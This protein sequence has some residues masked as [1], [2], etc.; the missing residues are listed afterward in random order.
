MAESYD[1]VVVGGGP[2][3]YVAAIR[4]AQLG[5]KTALIEKKELGGTCLNR[6]CIPTKALINSARLLDE[7]RNCGDKGIV[8]KE[9]SLN[10]EK[11]MERKDG[12]VWQLRSGVEYLLKAN[13]VDVIKGE[14]F[15]EDESTLCVRDDETI[16]QIKFADCIVATGSSPAGVA[17]EGA[18]EHTVTSDDLLSVKA[19][20]DRLVIIGGGVV[21]C[22]FAQIFHSFGSQ[23]TVVE[24]LPR[25]LNQADV[26][27]SSALEQEMSNKG[28]QVKTRCAVKKIRGTDSGKEVVLSCGEKEEL[29]CAD[30]VLL[31]VGRR[32]NLE[33]VSQLGLDMNGHYISVNEKMQTSKEHIYA[34]GDITGIRPLA[35]VASDMGKI[36]AENIAGKESRYDDT[37]VPSCIFTEPEMAYI[38]ITE[39]EARDRGIDINI[40]RFPLAA[41]G[42]ALIMGEANGFVKIIC[43]AETGKILGAHLLGG[44]A[45]EL[46]AELAAYM[47]M[48]ACADDICRTI[49]AHPTV[50][51]AV[52]EAAMDVE[53][54]C[55]HMP[56]S[57]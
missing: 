44:C 31:S 23:V 51:E 22:E 32:P 3:G 37:L 33:C 18:I 8:A 29:L 27:L 25:L 28:I 40:G 10:M 13:G 30:Q 36:A 54:I 48:E 5:K 34:I 14:A 46:I 39:E 45:T 53:G 2:G 24:A 42:K 55:I 9:I 16:S 50:S 21:G 11:V 12:V 17:I 7:I 41:N 43:H 56:P 57:K 52:Q 6:G 47:G 4:S 26:E 1:V 35:H 20:P 15:V 19:V 38:G 49:H